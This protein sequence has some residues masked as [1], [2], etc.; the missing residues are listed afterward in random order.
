MI[1]EK[2]RKNLSSKIEEIESLAARQS[3]SPQFN[4]WRT[5]TEE[6]IRDYFGEGNETESFN[7]IFYSPLFL[8]CSM[9]DTAFAESYLRGLEEARKVL[10]TILRKAGQMS[11]FST[12]A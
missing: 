10:E 7:A 11:S 6:L 12:Q 3:C 1:K 5:S 2:F 4:S 9:D 8:S